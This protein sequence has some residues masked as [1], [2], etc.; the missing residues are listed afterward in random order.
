MNGELKVYRRF[1]FLLYVVAFL[2]DF[3]LGIYLILGPVMAAELTDNNILLGAGG[4][5]FFGSRILLQLFFGRLSDYIGRKKI[6]ILSLVIFSS[7]FIVLPFTKNIPLLLISYLLA[8]TSNAMFWPIIEAWIGDDVEGANLIRSIGAFNIAFSLGLAIGALISG[9]L[10]VL[11]IT[12]PVAIALLL[13][14]ISLIFILSRPSHSP[15]KL[16]KLSSEDDHDISERRD[17]VFLKIAWVANFINAGGTGALRFLF[18]ELT[19]LYGIGTGFYGVIISCL[20]FSMSI[21]FVI[22]R[23]A[24]FWQYRLYPLLISQVIGIIGFSLLGFFKSGYIFC[25]GLLLF[26]V[27]V[28]TSY[29]SSIFY[30]LDGHADKGT[31]SGLHETFQAMGMVAAVLVGSILAQKLSIRAPYF[32]VACVI[33]IGMIIEIF[34]F[35]YRKRRR[36]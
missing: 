6:I 33:F 24:H 13:T 23:K 29:F 22:M 21:I 5:I 14:V 7:S 18:V 35:A 3:A 28:S 12:I 27:A 25:A 1:K 8:G 4:V 20:Y 26:G 34:L 17:P 9:Y 11:N 15:E 36:V 32:L 19:I 30:G 10:K 31:K 16:R 2:V